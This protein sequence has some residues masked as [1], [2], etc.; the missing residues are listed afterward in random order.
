MKD[1]RV[2]LKTFTRVRRFLDTGIDLFLLFYQHFLTV[3]DVET[4]GI[5]L[6]IELPSINRE[7]PI[8][9]KIEH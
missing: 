1:V 3:H 7:P 8:T 9:L 4:F 6:A 5:G 2:L